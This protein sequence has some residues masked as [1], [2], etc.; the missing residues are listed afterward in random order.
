MVIVKLENIKDT[1]IKLGLVCKT[2]WQN[3][4]YNFTK[5]NN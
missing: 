1:L 3:H 5:S 2:L 4:W